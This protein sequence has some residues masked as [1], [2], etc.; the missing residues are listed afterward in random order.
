MKKLDRWSAKALD[1]VLSIVGVP[2][3]YVLLS[4][5]FVLFFAGLLSAVRGEPRGYW[6]LM[7]AGVGV[8]F[9][10]YGFAHLLGHRDHGPER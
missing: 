6:W 8:G 5:P 9:I 2:I 3:L 10:A 4:S 1:D 7:P